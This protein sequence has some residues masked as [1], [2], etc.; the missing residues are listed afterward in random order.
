MKTRIHDFLYPEF[1]DL[2]KKQL[3]IIRRYE[4]NKNFLVKK[5]TVGVGITTLIAHVAIYHF[6]NNERVLIY[7]PAHISSRHE[8]C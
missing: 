3:D 1:I 4:V 8:P 7:C 2:I 5:H 6:C